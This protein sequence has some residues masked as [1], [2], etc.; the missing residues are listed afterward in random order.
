MF[1]TPPAT[2]A[3]PSPALIA[4]AALAIACSPE[5]QRRLTV[6]PGTSTGK[7]ASSAA[8]R[9]TLRLSSPAWFV[10]PRIT[11][12]RRAGSKETRSTA[13]RTAMAARS[14]ARTSARAPPARPTGVRTAETIRASRMHR[15]YQVPLP[16]E[17]DRQVRR[18]SVQAIAQH[19][20]I[21]GLAVTDAAAHTDRFRDARGDVRLRLDDKEVLMRDNPSPDGLR[22]DGPRRACGQRRT[23]IDDAEPDVSATACNVD[24]DI[25][26]PVDVE[27][28]R[29]D[30]AAG[31]APAAEANPAELARL[32]S[33]DDAAVRHPEVARAVGQ[34]V[35]R[36]A[37]QQRVVDEASAVDA[38]ELTR[39]VV[40]G[41]HL[42]VGRQHPA[43]VNPLEDERTVCRRG[44]VLRIR[45]GRNEQRRSKKQNLHGCLVRLMLTVD[46]SPG[47]ALMS[48]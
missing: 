33:D 22:R 19:V 6:C 4:C 42:V 14:S 17:L 9:A 35:A 47:L 23:R 21:G 48:V 36:A 24:L 28:E 18:R 26:L 16:A 41:G 29:R 7:P 10:Q 3:S 43:V 40:D 31:E 2:N 13:P 34:P 32:P 46:V 8:I 27:P 1:S 11:S 39:A 30:A 5:P 37:N 15:G 38:R 44:R 25:A 45:S 20:G 12:S